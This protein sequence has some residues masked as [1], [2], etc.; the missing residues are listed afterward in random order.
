MYPIK[1]KIDVFIINGRLIFGYFIDNVIIADSQKE[2]PFSVFFIGIII[3]LIILPHF[4]I[5][6]PDSVKI[7]LVGANVT[8]TDLIWIPTKNVLYGLNIG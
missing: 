6:S 8:L 4:Q 3:N 7:K 5:R 2:V 1:H